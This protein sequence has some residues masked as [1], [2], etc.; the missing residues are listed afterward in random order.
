MEEDICVL[1]FI[2][3]RVQNC[4]EIPSALHI[5]VLLRKAAKLSLPSTSRG[6]CNTL[7]DL[8]TSKEPGG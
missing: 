5:L 3:G 4:W 2:F 6:I 8:S 7:C 1:F